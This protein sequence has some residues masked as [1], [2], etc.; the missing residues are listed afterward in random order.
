MILLLL[1]LIIIIITTTNNHNNHNTIPACRRAGASGRSPRGV[2]D[3]HLFSTRAAKLARNAS[4][5]ASGR[6]TYISI[7]L[8]ILIAPLIK[9][10]YSLIRW[11]G[12]SRAT[13][14]EAL[15]GATM[16]NERSYLVRAQG[17]RRVVSRTRAWSPEQLG[18]RSPRSSQ[19]QRH[20]RTPR[21][22][23]LLVSRH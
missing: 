21:E 9:Q 20:L 22:C 17:R 14:G 19:Q 15:A 11:P 23:H 2:A 1:L 4:G 10:L 3:G 18:V 13:R 12:E 5:P 8:I 16:S 6:I 7:I